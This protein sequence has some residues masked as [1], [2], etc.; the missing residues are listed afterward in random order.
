MKNLIREASAIRKCTLLKLPLHGKTQILIPKNLDG[1]DEWY[2]VFMWDLYK[3][4]ASPRKKLTK[5]AH[6]TSY[7]DYSI[8]SFKVPGVFGALI[9]LEVFM[10]IGCVL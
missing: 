10:M 6:E 8:P 1:P 2:R 7:L 3:R 9:P 4:W 5:I